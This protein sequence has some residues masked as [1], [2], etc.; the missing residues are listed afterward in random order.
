MSD[1]YIEQRDSVYI[2]A[3]SRVSLDS[4]VHAFLSSQS[5]EAIAE[6]VLNLDQVY[7]AIT[8]YLAHR[9]DVDRY[10]DGWQKTSRP[11][12]SR[13]RCRS[14]V[15]PEAHRREEAD[16]AHALDANS[17]PSGRGSE[18]GHRVCRREACGGNRLQDR[19][20]SRFGWPEGSRRSRRRRT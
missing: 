16:S 20:V 9:D 19:D 13:A 1:A 4:T 11:L 15:L 18:S 5:A 8:Y 6:A 12:D 2:V 3:G 14:G 17:L 7:G 10:L